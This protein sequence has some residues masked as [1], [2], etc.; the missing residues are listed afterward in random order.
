MGPGPA[1]HLQVL[2]ERASGPLATLIVR[3]SGVHSDHPLATHWKHHVR[4]PPRATWRFPPLPPCG[5]ATKGH[6]MKVE[7]VLDRPLAP[8]RGSG[9]LSHHA[10]AEPLTTSTNQRENSESDRAPGLRPGRMREQQGRPRRRKGI[11]TS[12]ESNH[13][14]EASGATPGGGARAHPPKQNITEKGRSPCKNP[15]EPPSECPHSL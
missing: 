13:S 9:L 7:M 1:N 3:S 2:L 11:K 4:R 12:E 15:A 8:C 10:T 14:S 5:K 6:T